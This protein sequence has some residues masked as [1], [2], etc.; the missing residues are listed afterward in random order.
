MKRVLIV[1]D[2]PAVADVI[3]FALRKAG[4][5][6]RV[7]PGTRRAKEELLP[8]LFAAMILDILCGRPISAAASSPFPASV[9]YSF[10]ILAGLKTVWSTF[11]TA[12]LKRSAKAARQRSTTPPSS[13][14]R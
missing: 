13:A 4:F 11:T 14:G 6:P 5:E 9:P 7:A 12:S 10:Q 2:E 3:E 8:G 1:E